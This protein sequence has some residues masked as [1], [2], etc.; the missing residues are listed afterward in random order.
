MAGY[1]LTEEFVRFVREKRKLFSPFG[2][3]CWYASLRRLE[4]LGH[5]RHHHTDDLVYR[6]AA[7]NCREQWGVR[8]CR[9]DGGLVRSTALMSASLL[10]PP[11]TAR[12]LLR[13]DAHGFAGSRSEASSAELFAKRRLA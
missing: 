3:G 8:S 6:Y 7:S 5:I 10:V 2:L 4:H 12:P 11:S 13:S 1:A 9:A